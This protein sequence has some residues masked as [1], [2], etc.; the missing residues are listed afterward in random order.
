MVR[1]TRFSLAIRR[2]LV[3]LVIAMMVP[4]VTRAQEMPA[5]EEPAAA[6]K[7]AAK[8]K[9][10]AAAVDLAYD[11]KPNQEYHYEV[12]IEAQLP[13]RKQTYQG[14]SIYRV[15]NG[16]AGQVTL[17]HVG[18]L[19]KNEVLSPAARSQT[20][21]GARGMRHAIP[22]STPR[23]NTWASRG[24]GT[25]TA[26]EVTINQRGGV[27]QMTGENPMPL[28]LGDLAMLVIEPLAE[29]RERD[30]E[31]NTG[32]NVV[33]KKPAQQGTTSRSR[34]RSS[35][36]PQS[37]TTNRA[38][39]EHTDY[40]IKDVKGTLVTILKKSQLRTAADTTAANA[41]E[42]ES[43]GE[44]VFDR[45][46]GVMAKANIKLVNTY[47]IDG[48]AVQVPVVVQYRLLSDKEVAKNAQDKKEASEERA[49][50][51]AKAEKEATRSLTNAETADLIGA[52]KDPGTRRDAAETLGKRKTPDRHQD[53]VAKALNPLLADDDRGVRDAAIKALKVWGTADNVPALI[54]VVSDDDDGG[55]RRNAMD[56]LGKLKDK[57]GAKAV[58]DQFATSRGEARRA[59]EQMGA[60]A[61]PYVW[62]L[63]EAP[64]IGVR[65]DA[66]KLLASI[67]TAKSQAKLEKLVKKSTG[68]DAKAAQEALDKIAKR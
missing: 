57:R 29:T 47:H 55:L 24:R 31:V 53:K 50:K 68:S 62:P 22:H 21:G 61:E 19:Q 48:V 16:T 38:G 26:H 67:G 34:L 37:T 65:A 10:S 9:T 5:E 40:R 25:S 15:R 46:N 35:Q 17:V 56:V 4:A 28:L 52:L 14:T 51:R 33:E 42:Q 49:D 11:W 18:A 30:W 39:G 13:D 12:A 60:M 41:Y 1:M 3:A 8:K 66:C 32:L 36:Q 54:K 27:L 20:S 7:A 59:L 44:L 43:A 63:L 2:A 23:P 6:K 64:D 58:A 45:K